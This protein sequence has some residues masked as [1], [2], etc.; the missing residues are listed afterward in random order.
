MSLKTNPWLHLWMWY[1]VLK[2]NKGDYTWKIL[3]GIYKNS[4]RI[5]NSTFTILNDAT[6]IRYTYKVTQLKESDVFFV[7]FLNGSDN[8]SSFG[9]IGILTKNGFKH[10]K[11]SKVSSDAIVFKSFNWLWDVLE[12]NKSVPSSFHFYHEGK[13]AKCG[14]KLT[15][16]QSIERGFGPVCFN[17]KFK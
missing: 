15:T 8:E 9:Y 2:S 11:K 5:V 3:K 10:T 4:L 7:S 12:N 16:P 14:R 6:D 1:N 13:C 17:T